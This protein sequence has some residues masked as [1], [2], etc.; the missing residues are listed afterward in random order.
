MDSGV[1]RNKTVHELAAQLGIADLEKFLRVFVAISS[2]GHSPET[3]LPL[4]KVR[5]TVK[6]AAGILGVSSRWLFDQCRAE[7]VAHT[8]L[9]RHR[10]FTHEQLVGLL[11]QH[12][13]KPKEKPD[14]EL[15]RIRRQVER[16]RVGARRR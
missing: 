12:E 2:A 5:Y 7:R 14:P 8:N 3:Q 11:R 13:V 6:E 1:R 9:A 10:F 15:E 16:G 4:P